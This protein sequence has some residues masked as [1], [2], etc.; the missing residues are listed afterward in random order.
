LGIIGEGQLF[1]LIKVRVVVGIDAADLASKLHGMLIEHF[2]QCVFER[3][4]ASPVAILVQVTYIRAIGPIGVQTLREQE[5]IGA[6]AK[7]IS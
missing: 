4:C 6:N 7:L 1:T 5:V 3:V 2:T